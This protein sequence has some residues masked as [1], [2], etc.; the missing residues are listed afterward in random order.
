MNLYELTR[1]IIDS[2]PAQ[3]R[4]SATDEALLMQHRSALLALEEELVKGFY[5]E[6]EANPNINA[7]LGEGSRAQRETTLRRWWQ[8]TLAGPIDEKYW[9]WQALVGVVHIKVGVKNPMMMGMW[10]WIL[11]RLRERVTADVVGS[12]DVAAQLMDCVERL[13]LTTQAITAESF[14]M[15]YLETVIRLTGFK[16]ALLERMFKTEINLVLAE[17]REQLGDTI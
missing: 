1:S 9:A 15:N 14:L 11:A 10:R 6:I 8:R 5:D 13:A 4:F 17:A 16:P 2:I 3:Q 7:L 12:A